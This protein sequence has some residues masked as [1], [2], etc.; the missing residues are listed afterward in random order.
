M[1]LVVLY[2]ATGNAA[3]VHQNQNICVLLNQSTF[4]KKNLLNEFT[5]IGSQRIDFCADLN[6]SIS[7]SG[8]WLICVDRTWE[9]T[10]YRQ[11]LVK[12]IELTPELLRKKNRT[13]A[14]KPIKTH[15]GGFGGKKRPEQV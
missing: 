9:K 4:L 15:A 8:G 11:E 1:L 10:E 13:H 2:D 12:N 7:W 14:R 6:Q 5:F 3:Y